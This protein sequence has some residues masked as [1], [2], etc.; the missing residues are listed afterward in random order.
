[1]DQFDTFGLGKNVPINTGNE[2]EGLLALKDGKWVVPRVRYPARVFHEV[3]GRPDR[4]G[5]RGGA[6]PTRH[7]LPIL[8]GSKGLRFEP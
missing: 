7:P 1:V 8:S 4:R 3:G 6:R 2:S 5:S